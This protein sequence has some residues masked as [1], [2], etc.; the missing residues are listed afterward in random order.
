MDEQSGQVREAVLEVTEQVLE[1]QLRAVR[2]LRREGVKPEKQPRQGMSQLDM[3]FDI[4]ASSDAPKHVNDII[5]GI[6]ERFGSKV[7][8]ESLVSALSKRVARKD[9]FYRDAPN[10]FGLIKGGEGHAA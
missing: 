2:S 7:D 10:V 1:A 6:A 5:A 3:A 8:R 9:R 4:L